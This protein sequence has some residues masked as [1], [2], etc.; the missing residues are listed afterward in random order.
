MVAANSRRLAH[1]SPAVILRSMVMSDLVK[2]LLHGRN[3]CGI[4]FVWTAQNNRSA[5]FKDM[6]GIMERN[7]VLNILQEN[8]KLLSTFLSARLAKMLR[9]ILST[10]NSTWR[11]CH[12]YGLAAS[13]HSLNEKI[14]SEITATARH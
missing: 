8:H 12:T 1:V 14:G 13:S 11:S 5:N 10:Y 4:D 2:P 3:N 6:A 7:F 9:T